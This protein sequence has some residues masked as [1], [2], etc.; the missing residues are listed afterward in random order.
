[1]GAT[2]VLF[3]IV[4]PVYN[5]ERYL[6]EC[7]QSIIP[8]AEMIPEGCEIILVDDGSTDGSGTICDGYRT[9]Y[10]NLIQVYHR[11]N[12][13]L[14]LTRRFGYKHTS[15]QYIINCDSD[16]LLERDALMILKESIKN[17]SYPD[18]IIF[19]H[20]RYVDGRKEDE[21]KDI[22]TTA[23]SC[24]VNKSDV[25][26]EYLSGYSIVSVWGGICH[27]SC[28]DINK[29]Y[30]DYAKFNA[31]EDSLQKLEQFDRAET[32]VYINKP[33]YDYRAS[34][35]MTAKFNPEYYSS[36]R[37]IFDEILKRKDSWDIDHE[38]EYF[39]LK[40]LGTAGRAIT[41]SRYKRWSNKEDQRKYLESIQKDSVFQASY[42][43]IGEVKKKLQRD[44]TILTKLLYKKKFG[45]IIFLLNLKNASDKI[46]QR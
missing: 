3:S 15:G 24:R 9:K 21:F 37:K 31:G 39:A 2:T 14:L 41:Q 42:R 40:V 7:L 12:H 4:I 45:T 36:F 11:S 13:G 22:F 23:E 19:N 27:R 44:H 38:E 16:D 28:I 20:Y 8:Q 34:S 6:D 17:Y 46:H 26:K 1:M 33:L 10:P 29:D 18:M 5:V 25:L 35:G 32:Y 30:S 43:Y